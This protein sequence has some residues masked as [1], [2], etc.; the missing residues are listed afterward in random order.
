MNDCQQ[1]LRKEG[2]PYPRTCAKCGLGP[3]RDGT[4]I[5]SDLSSVPAAEIG[6]LWEQVKENLKRLNE[7][8]RHR[9]SAETVKV[10]DKLT[11][12]NCHGECRLSDIGV[13]I[14]G[15]IAAGGKAADVWPA[16]K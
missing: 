9:F 6:D 1:A 12:E 10:G 8:K 4:Q 15:Y 7:C 5:L 16:W 14:R 11:C 3:C 2:K 13:Y